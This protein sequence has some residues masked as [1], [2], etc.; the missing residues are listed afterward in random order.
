MENKVSAW[1]YKG[2]ILVIVFDM[3]IEY[4]KYNDE[5]YKLYKLTPTMADADSQT[6]WGR[7]SVDGVWHARYLSGEKNL[8]PSP[9]NTM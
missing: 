1:N 3:L 7:C 2:L 5:I 8:N 4:F 6:F 9:I